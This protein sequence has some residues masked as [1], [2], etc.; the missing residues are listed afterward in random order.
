MD[1]RRRR[2]HQQLSISYVAKRGRSQR[3]CRIVCTIKAPKSVLPAEVDLMDALIN[4]VGFHDAQ[5]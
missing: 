1:A 5:S 3:A 2:S 4:G